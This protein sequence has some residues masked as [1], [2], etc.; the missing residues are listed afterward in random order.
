MQRDLQLHAC[1]AEHECE[2]HAPLYPTI[3][4]D[5]VPWMARGIYREEFKACD[6]FG[7][8]KEVGSVLQAART[9]VRRLTAG[10]HSIAAPCWQCP[11]TRLLGHVV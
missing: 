6:V 10:R 1:C 3:L 4:D 7:S 9:P 5:L 11:A 2:E 8:K